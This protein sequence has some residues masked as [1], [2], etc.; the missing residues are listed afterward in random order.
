MKASADLSNAMATDSIAPQT[1][2]L[3]LL[4]R[5]GRSSLR[6]C[7][8]AAFGHAH[9]WLLAAEYIIP[10]QLQLCFSNAG[11]DLCSDTRNTLDRVDP[12]VRACRISVVVDPVC[13]ARQEYMVI[14]LACAGWQRADGLI[15]EV[16]HQPDK[17]LSDG[18][19]ALTSG[20]QYDQAGQE[21][22]HS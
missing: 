9:E 16:H 8:S 10:R 7:S 17:A 18:A 19:Q 15:V 21:C 14:P 2:K 5:V 3:S 12:A 13:M 11:A 1:C 22:D 4:R 20:K 6:S